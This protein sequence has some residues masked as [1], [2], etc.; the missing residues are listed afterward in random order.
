MGVNLSDIVPV[1]RAQLEDLRGRTL[2]VDAYNTI[3]QFLSII[4]QPDGTPLKDEKGRTTSHLTGLLYR[5]INLLEQDIRPVYVFDGVPH[6][7]K[8]ET[9][10]E[11][12]E[13]RTKAG[14]DWKVAVENGDIEKAYSKATQSSRMTNDIAES[15]RIL[16]N[17][18]GSP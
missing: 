10:L 12:H 4:R 8:A 3:Y 18:L 2:A 7:M 1:E 5:N 13:R 14:D 17:L 11:R 15:S 16:L 9:L 6:R